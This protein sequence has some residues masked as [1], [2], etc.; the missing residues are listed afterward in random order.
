LRALLQQ[1]F[2]LRG[3]QDQSVIRG[4]KL[5]EKGDQAQAL[6]AFM[7]FYSRRLMVGHLIRRRNSNVVFDLLKLA[8]AYPPAAQAVAMIADQIA[9]EIRGHLAGDEDISDWCTIIR[10]LGQFDRAW[11]LYNELLTKDKV[12]AAKLSGVVYAQLITEKRYN[13]ALDTALENTRWTLDEVEPQP[14]NADDQTQLFSY[15]LPAIYEAFE[16]LLACGEKE[17]SAA[18]E[19]WAMSITP[20]ASIYDGLIKAA[21]RAGKTEVAERL[22]LAKSEKF[23]D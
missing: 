11:D 7:T 19:Q 20:Q 16:V 9:G 10:H 14:K 1:A 21:Q 15:W 23:P 18:L 13:E 4:R 6:E 17:Q 3:R 12:T 8:D 22:I 2:V 5:M